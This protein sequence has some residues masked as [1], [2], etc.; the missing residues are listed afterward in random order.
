M[1]DERLARLAQ[2]VATMAIGKEELGFMLADFEAEGLNL[3]VD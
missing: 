2:E 3:E 1:T